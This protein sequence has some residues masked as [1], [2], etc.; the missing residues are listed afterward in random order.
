VIGEGKNF[1]A[2]REEGRY[3]VNFPYVV[4]N[5]WY[6]P[7]YR[8]KF[9]TDLNFGVWNSQLNDLKGYWF[10]ISPRA[11]FSDRFTTIYG[12]NF[13]ADSNDLD[14]N[15]SND[16]DIFYAYRKVVTIENTLEANYVFNR[17]MSLSLVGRYYW[18]QVNNHS[19]YTLRDDGLFDFGAEVDDPGTTFGA[20]SSD[21][22][23]SY[24]FLPG[25]WI[26]AAWKWNSFLDEG[27]ENRYGPSFRQT[28]RNDPV[29][30]LSLKVLYYLDYQDLK[31]LKRKNV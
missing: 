21:L 27:P 5:I 8:K 12:F 1:Y 13:D 16:D 17:K 19:F 20:F 24:E 29:N 11:R 28:L 2:P 14:Y 7:D 23:Y 31:K 26:T 22:I 15:S 25:S 6:S 10:G 4:A 3:H 30:R 18:S 9:L